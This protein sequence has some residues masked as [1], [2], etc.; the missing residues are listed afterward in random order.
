MLQLIYFYVII[1]I[2]VVRKWMS[3]PHL[4]GTLWT[5]SSEYS[6]RKLWSTQDITKLIYY[7]YLGTYKEEL[8]SR[9]AQGPK[10]PEKNLFLPPDLRRLTQLSRLSLIIFLPCC[11]AV[12]SYN[13]ASTLWGSLHSSSKGLWAPSCTE[14]IH[15][16]AQQ[17]LLHSK[18]NSQTYRERFTF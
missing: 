14:M 15:T 10:T 13:P 2:W 6:P 12:Y 17:T 8:Y 7:G 4:Q 9:E 5:L 1:W 18:S 11:L 16:H 3:S